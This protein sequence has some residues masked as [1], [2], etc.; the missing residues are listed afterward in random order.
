MTVGLRDIVTLKTG[1]PEMLILR[2]KDKD[3]LTKRDPSV[4]CEWF[5]GKKGQEQT[6]PLEVLQLIAKRRPCTCGRV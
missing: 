1:G 2:F 5:D 3:N 4:L 6:Y